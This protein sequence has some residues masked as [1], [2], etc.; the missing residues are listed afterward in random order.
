MQVQF[1]YFLLCPG[2]GFR[3]SGALIFWGGGGEEGGSRSCSRQ[4]VEGA[5]KRPGQREKDQR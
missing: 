1:A 2:L 3:P 4:K 5:N